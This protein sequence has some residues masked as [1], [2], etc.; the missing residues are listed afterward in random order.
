MLRKL[1]YAA[2]AAILLLSLAC[3]QSSARQ[4]AGSRLF[5]GA[6]PETAAQD[7]AAAVIPD[8]YA[9]RDSVIYVPAPAADSAL[10][11]KNIFM[12]LPSKVKGNPA[13]VRVHQSP[14]ILSAMNSHFEANRGKDV[15]GY[16]VRI[17]FD[18]KQ[19]ARNESLAVMNKFSAEYHDIPVY[20]SYVN[21]Y[22]K[23]TVGDFRSKSEAMQLLRRIRNEFPAAFIV[24]EKSISY[25]A[26]DRNR[27]MVADTVR[28]MYRIP[29][30]ITL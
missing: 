19:T 28:I 24:K 18:N 25:P 10:V 26:I 4:F 6:S 5:T 21:P 27:A 9:V 1:I 29:E 8:G 16:R 7:T 3:Q 14:E 12:I 20:R 13:D 22:F 23:V 15:S 17:F 30:E 11:G 2:A